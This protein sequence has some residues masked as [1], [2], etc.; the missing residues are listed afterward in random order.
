MQK[1]WPE[2]EASAV[3]AAGVVELGVGPLFLSAQLEVP[4]VVD[5]APDSH[6][7]LMS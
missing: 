3:I 4:A 7:S 2:W 5:A 6:V 1:L